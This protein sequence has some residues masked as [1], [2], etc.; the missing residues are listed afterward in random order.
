MGTLRQPC[1][2][3]CLRGLRVSLAAHFALFVS[4]AASACD[5]EPEV[6]PSVEEERSPAPASFERSAPTEVSSAEPATV[7]C[8]GPTPIRISVEDEQALD[9][10]IDAELLRGRI[11]GA[12]VVL[13]DADGVAFRRAYGDAARV[14]VTR[15]MR[16]D[17]IFDL[18]SVTKLVV[19]IAAL[20]WMEENETGSEQ[21][22]VD[23][24]LPELAGRGIRLAD[25]LGHTAG[26]APANPLSEYG[27][28]REDS[29]AT[30]LQHAGGRGGS[31]RRYSDVG[32]IALGAYLE[33]ATHQS[34]QE[35]LEEYLISPAGLHEMGYRSVRFGAGALA[36][37]LV[38]T[39]FAARRGAP[40]PMIH[41]IVNDPR[42]FR[43]EGMA[44]NAGLFSTA[45]DLAALARKLLER[46]FLTERSRRLLS[47]WTT[48]ETGK[49]SQSG[50]TGTW[51]GIDLESARFAIVLTNRVHPN[52][53][54]RAQRLRARIRRAWAGMRLRPGNSSRSV[55]TGV[56]VL[57][58]EGFL[59]L[60]GHRLAILTNGAARAR[61]GMPTWR[62][63]DRETQLVR[64]F[65]PEH[66]LS[67]GSEGEI[68]SEGRVI[69]LFGQRRAP[70]AED[71]EGVDR[72]L[73]DL[74]D[75]GVRFFTYASTALATLR[76]AAEH[77]VP[78]TVLDRPNPLGGQ[79]RGPMLDPAMSSFVNYHPLPILHGFTLGELLHFLADANDLPRPEIVQVRGWHRAFRFSETGLRWVPPSPNLGTFGQVRL[80]PGIALLEASNLSVG[81]GTDDAFRVVGAPG[82]DSEALLTEL[83]FP[84]VRFA[85]A[86]FRPRSGPYRGQRCQGV[87]M[88]LL[89]DDVDVVGLG[90]HLF[91]VFSQ[92]Q[93]MFE[94]RRSD[95]MLGRVGAAEALHNGEPVEIAAQREALEEFTRIRQSVLFPEYAEG[96]AAAGAR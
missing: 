79:V 41:G 96:S 30:L 95:R 21:A 73:I 91:A 38:P 71:F 44:G 49:I 45:D 40:P 80:Y 1:R 61:D 62:L 88:T 42:S 46:G 23:S 81:R 56:D 9:E 12:V 39:E 59:S 78:V 63:L 52:G 25:L 67:A 7:P 31:E 8:T 64:I 13:G 75:V 47:Q 66:G 86:R 22:L 24:V 60:Q 85:R 34:L 11:P 58:C 89:S 17:A 68:P 84:G 4:F 48:A 36:E 29:I 70:R 92:T 35:F 76:V 26:F 32:Y 69:S 18:A 57:R 19:A 94:P 74:P 33:R 16:E 65:T 93:A 72:L 55:Y 3:L 20:R 90:L 27:E 82:V 2:E 87:R 15:P 14:P 51:I 10:I 77:N 6:A 50:Y 43:L 83:A 28:D 54:G 5:G 53:E 37:R